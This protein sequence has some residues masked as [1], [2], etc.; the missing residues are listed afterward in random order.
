[1]H[2]P[3]AWRHLPHFEH[4]GT[5]STIS[6]AFQHQYKFGVLQLIANFMP[7]PRPGGPPQQSAELLRRYR[8]TFGFGDGF[9][10][11]AMALLP[12][13][14][15]G[16]ERRDGR[17][18]NHVFYQ[19]FRERFFCGSPPTTTHSHGAH[20]TIRCAWRR[21]LKHGGVCAG[22][23]LLEIVGIQRVLSPHEPGGPR[24]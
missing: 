15:C 20:S 23:K 22:S 3:A 8:R 24:A 1:M 17:A 2:G 5:T 21:W 14:I 9:L 6:P 4:F 18:V 19:P 11:R 12:G 16:R 10:S 7:W 13:I